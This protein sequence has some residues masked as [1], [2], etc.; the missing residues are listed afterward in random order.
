[1]GHAALRVFAV[2][3]VLWFLG[4]ILLGAGG[5][6]VMLAS[7]G[8]WQ[9]DQPAQG[10]ACTSVH[11][12]SSRGWAAVQTVGSDVWLTAC[13]DSTGQLRAVSGPTCRATSF[14]G[15]GT[16]TCAAISEGGNLK[17]TVQVDYPFG[18]DLIAGP[19]ASSFTVHSSGSWSSP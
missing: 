9:P 12:F 6:G 15:A 1:M 11:T 13:K 14:L 18:L 7:S 8:Q 2:G 17:V 10:P 3:A 4:P 19:L 5:T 16:A